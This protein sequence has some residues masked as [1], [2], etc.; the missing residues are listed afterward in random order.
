MPQVITG[1][2]Y[3]LASALG[4]F[5][6]TAVVTAAIGL[7]I[8]AITNALFGRGS[9]KSEATE[10]SIKNPTPLR[11]YACGKRRMFGTSML[12]ETASNGSSVDVFAFA[13]GPAN[14]ITQVY[15]NDD[16]V[17]II[18]GVVQ[19][20]E[21]GRYRSAGSGAP[22]LG[23]PG[24]ATVAAGYNLGAPVETAHEAVVSVFEGVWGT[25]GTDIWTE[26]HRGDGIVSGYLI[27]K[28]VEAED[29]IDIYPQGD[30]V[31]MSL[32]GEWGKFFDPRNAAHD[33]L[34]HLTWEYTD[35]AV[36]H[37]LWYFMIYRG[38][39]YAR[40][41]EPVIGYWITAANDADIS[42][43]L[44]A[45]GSEPRYRGCV[46][47]DGGKKPGDILSEFLACFD[48]WTDVDG[49]GCQVVYSGRLYEP[50]VSIAAE[51]I[52]DYRHQAFVPEEDALNEIVI[53]YVSEIHDFNTVEAQSWR[54]ETDIT[55]RGVILSDAIEPQVPSHTQARRLAKRIMS[56]RNAPDRGWCRTK[57][58]GRE[59]LGQ[60][61][62]NLTIEEAGAIFFD[63]VAEI[64]GVERDY[65][66]GGVNFEWVAVDANIDA[67]NPA[68]EDGEGAPTGNRVALEP[69]DAPTI[70]TATPIVNDSGFAQVDVIIND[71]P[72]RDDLTWYGRWKISA[73]AIWNEQQYS[74]VDA[75]APV[76]LLI[77]PVPGGESVDVAVKYRVGDGRSSAWSASE[78]VTTGEG[79]IDYDGGDAGTEV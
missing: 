2:I 20:G 71:A 27:K 7:G 8:S 10:R 54:D 67:W 34:N 39:D 1:I 4:G 18:D 33:P 19:E 60:R 62:I 63:G 3:G 48:G 5:L 38:F 42:V 9:A 45:G 72:V 6:A 25:G 73:D 64:T 78:T 17:T 23:G 59:V 43:A 21:D 44:D 51:Q 22:W 61:Y 49:N 74:D 31:T 56:R 16:K 53:H 40:K 14:A 12:F 68:T 76:E 70:D 69:V 79:E 66:T 36:L 58:G 65:D 11:Q 57:F 32:A 24:G 50:T 35:N 28:P 30:N 41:L 15:L 75:G 46:A 77:G 47:F 52:I 29:F 55:D 26:N 13:E 37:T